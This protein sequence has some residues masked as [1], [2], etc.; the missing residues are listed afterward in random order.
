MPIKKPKSQYQ[1]RSI[2]SSGTEGYHCLNPK[3]LTPQ[4]SE[5]QRN[6]PKAHDPVRW[7]SRSYIPK[8]LLACWMAQQLIPA[9]ESAPAPQRFRRG[10]FQTMA[11]CGA[12]C[13][14]LP[15]FR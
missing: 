4:S 14:V 8:L 9:H 7:I 2:D 5:T 15:W 6:G 12:W 10:D 1:V 11:E 13:P 3:A